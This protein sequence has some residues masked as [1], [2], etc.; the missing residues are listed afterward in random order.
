MSTPSV[1]KA[2]RFL[3]NRIVDQAKRANVPLTEVEA[4]MLAF[5]PA[6]ASP[7][8]Y[9]AAADFE[10]DFDKQKYEAKIAQLFRDVYAAD[11]SLARAE[12]WNSRWMR[13]RTKTFTS[14]RSSA[15]L[16]SASLRF[17]GFCPTCARCGSI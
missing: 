11:K 13:W 9:E 17:P 1:V 4:C 16:A 2:K 3:V 15:G 7:A 8:E 10:R 12:I 6:S 5:A 14:Q